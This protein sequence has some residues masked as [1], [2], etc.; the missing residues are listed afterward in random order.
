MNHISE[1]Y[2]VLAVLGITFLEQKTDVW[3]G[4]VT[5]RMNKI[6]SGFNSSTDMAGILCV[7]DRGLV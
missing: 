2:T 7:K 4:I 1:Y 3:Q 5:W 6:H